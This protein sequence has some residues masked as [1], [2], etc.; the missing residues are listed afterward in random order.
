MVHKLTDMLTF[1]HL[2]K[3]NAQGIIL[4]AA[5]DIGRLF[6]KVQIAF[7]MG[8][9]NLFYRGKSKKMLSHSCVII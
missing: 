9:I 1:W 4:Q 2:N 5:V 8:G 6:Y 3:P 7:M